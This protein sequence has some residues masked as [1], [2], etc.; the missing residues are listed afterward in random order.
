MNRPDEPTCKRLYNLWS[1]ARRSSNPSEAVTARAMLARQQAQLGLSDAE[2]AFIAENE[3]KAPISSDDSEQTALNVFE[4]LLHL[5]EGSAIIVDF[6]QVVV[7]AFW[8]LHAHVVFDH[9]RHTPRLMLRSRRPGCGKTTLLSLIKLLVPNGFKSDNA[10][11]ASLYSQ[12][13]ADP[14]STLLLD[15][16]EN[17]ALWSHDRFMRALLD[18]GHRYDGSFSRQIRGKNVSLSVF[19]PLAYALVSNRRVRVPEQLVS[20]SIPI[21]MQRHPEGR[22]EIEP[23]NPQIAEARRQIFEWALTFRRP[24]DCEIL[25]VGRDRDNFRPLL[26]IGEALDY[27]ETARAAV[28]EIYQPS[29]DLLDPLVFNIYQVFEQHKRSIWTTEL[30]SALHELPNAHW[31]EFRGIEGNKDPHKLTRGELYDLLD[32]LDPPIKSKSIQKLVG[33]ERKSHKGFDRAQFEPVWTQR[34]AGTPAHV[35]ALPR[36][37]KWQASDGG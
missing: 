30:L 10:T 24:P 36:H 17:S 1:V 16:M 23:D 2:V 33:A 14:R 31:D 9:Y 37:R 5:F 22:D 27:A 13:Q 29:E 7:V 25:F 19:A 26:E 12:L 18:A 21:D 6:A 3:E 4:L 11:P 32:K 20:R 35:I 8:I 28:L 34:F 15:E